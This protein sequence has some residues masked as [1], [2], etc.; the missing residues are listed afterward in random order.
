[1]IILVLLGFLS[2]YSCA[3][4]Q[5]QEQARTNKMKRRNYI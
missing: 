3:E 5:K 4:Y 1:M 2:G